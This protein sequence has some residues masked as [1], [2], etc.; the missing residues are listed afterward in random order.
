MTNY[1]IFL[2]KTFFNEKSKLVSE[3][4]PCIYSKAGLND[5]Q[6][7]EQLILSNVE[8]FAKYGDIEFAFI[9]CFKLEI[10]ES[11]AAKDFDLP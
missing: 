9:P 2:L 3:I 4:G 7:C 5:I 11:D 8:L 6:A 10:P 1:K